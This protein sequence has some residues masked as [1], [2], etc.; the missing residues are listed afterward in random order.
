MRVTFG[1]WTLDADRRLLLCDG[2]PA[3][4]SP[5]A[6]DLLRVLAEHHQR[7]FSK[8]ELHQQLWPDTF[9]SDGSL[10]ILIAEIRDVLGDDAQHPRFVRTVQR[11]GYAFCAEVLKEDASERRSGGDRSGWVIWGDKCVGLGAGQ[12]TLGRAADAGVR[13]DVP[14][15]SRHHA[16]ITVQGERATVEDLDSRNGTYLR[17][18]RITAPEALVDGDE[19]RLGPVTVVFRRVSPESSTFPMEGGSSLV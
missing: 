12:T 7:A 9:V 16:R 13:F 2:E 1:P 17:D 14:G 3:P 10:T 18:K 6:F 11:F 4:L 19:I 15:V 8:A 5:K